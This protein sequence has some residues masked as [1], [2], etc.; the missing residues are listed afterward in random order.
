MF[1]LSI[2]KSVYSKE[3]KEFTQDTRMLLIVF[4]IPLLF[5]PAV[6]LTTYSTNLEIHQPATKVAIIHNSCQQLSSEQINDTPC[7]G[8]SDKNNL[9]IKL[10]NAEMEALLDMT[11]QRV[12]FANASLTSDLTRQVI[13]QYYLRL[14]HSTTPSLSVEDLKSDASMVNVIGT[15]LASV[16]VMLVIVF[17][18]VGAL[19]FGIDV[20]T[21]EKER[22]SFKLYAEFKEK[23]VSIF[24]GKL[25][26]TSMCSALTAILGIIGIGISV[27]SIEYFYGDSAAMSQAEFDK[28]SAFFDY[29]RILTINDVLVTA[30]YL[31]PAIFVISSCVNLLGCLAKNMKEAKLLGIVLIIAIV[32]LTKLNLGD[33]YFFYTAFIPIL[34]V[35]SGVHNALTFEVDYSHLVVSLIVNISICLNTLF[36]I[37]K[38]I[39]KERI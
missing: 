23:I 6:T 34:N 39:I 21:G 14:A 10:Q 38:L 37:N 25:V 31:I 30:L 16:L 36:D 2:V 12:Y 28:V 7:Y 22:G 11:Q 29:L 20:T 19:N 1:N 4:L 24:A 27:V 33:E 18:F 3:F 15:S 17:S 35:F 8:L 9:L 26:F 5:M 32:A 13:E